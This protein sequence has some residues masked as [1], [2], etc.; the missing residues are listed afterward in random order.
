V[1]YRLV[2]RGQ[3]FTRRVMGDSVHSGMLSA[4]DHQSTAT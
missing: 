3:F 1:P 2:M 4:D